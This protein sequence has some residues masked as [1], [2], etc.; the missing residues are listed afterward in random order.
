LRQ[1]YHRQCPSPAQTTQGSLLSS[2]QCELFEDASIDDILD[3]YTSIFQQV[4]SDIHQPVTKLDFLG[5]RQL[6]RLAEW[7]AVEQDYPQ[8]TLNELFV[9]EAEMVPD[10]VA[11]IYESTRLTYREMDQRT[12]Q[13]P[14]YL[15]LVLPCAPN[16]VVGLILDNSELMF[17][18]ALLFQSLWLVQAS[19]SDHRN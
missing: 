19:A 9:Q 4:V 17:E 16:T 3:V 18:Q 7:N 11:L 5:Q 14:R 15:R 13:L 2:S 12:N 6:L 10:K 1:Q 8:L